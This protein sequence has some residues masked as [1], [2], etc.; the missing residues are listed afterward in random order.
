[1]GQ[2]NFKIK[3]DEKE[4]IVMET[5]EQTFEK[6]KSVVASYKIQNPVKYAQKEASFI[7]KLELLDP[8]RDAKA[9]KETE[10]KAKADAK[11][12][13]EAEKSAK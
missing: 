8:E 7:A 9:L 1:M 6:F 13:K 12:L 10:A 3:K 2:I 4:P 11:A 5:P